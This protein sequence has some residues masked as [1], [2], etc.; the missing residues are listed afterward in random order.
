MLCIVPVQWSP[1]TKGL[2]ATD[3][4]VTVTSATV[5]CR[6]SETPVGEENPDQLQSLSMKSMLG[7]TETVVAPESTGSGEEWK[8]MK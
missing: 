8:I 1:L 3:T 2:V 4:G 5:S 6:V 7:H